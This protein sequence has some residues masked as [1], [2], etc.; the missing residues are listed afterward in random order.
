LL[1]HHLAAWKLTSN[2]K[3]FYDP[4][5]KFKVAQCQLTTSARRGTVTP[6]D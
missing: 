1:H 6:T 5:V 3:G 2:P 4:L